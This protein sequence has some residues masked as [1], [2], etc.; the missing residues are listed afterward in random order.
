MILWKIYGKYDLMLLRR[1]PLFICRIAVKKT[2][3]HVSWWT[4][5]NFAHFHQLM[6][7][8]GPFQNLMCFD[9]PKTSCCLMDPYKGFQSF[10]LSKPHVFWWT[11]NLMWCDGPLMIFRVHHTTWGFWVQQKTRFDGPIFSNLNFFTENEF[12]CNF[13]PIE[14]ISLKAIHCF[15]HFK[16]AEI[17]NQINPIP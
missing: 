9:G 6:W 10:P 16:V 3:F 5:P 17:V 4:Q 8:D 7:F 1:G 15:Q 2:Q 14:Q 12:Q 13:G 11:Q